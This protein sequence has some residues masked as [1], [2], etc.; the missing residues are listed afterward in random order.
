MCVSGFFWRGGGGEIGKVC[1]WGGGKVLTKGV[2]LHSLSQNRV[3]VVL[4]H[5]LFSTGRP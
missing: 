2:I 4:Y 1:V 3:R 5:N